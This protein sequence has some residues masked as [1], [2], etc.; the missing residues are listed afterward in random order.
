M[1]ILRTPQIFSTWEYRMKWWHIVK[2]YNT[3][4]ETHRP[5]PAMQR[6]TMREKLL[7]LLPCGT[8]WLNTPTRADRASS[9]NWNT[10]VRVNYTEQ[11]PDF[12]QC[13]RLDWM[14]AVPNWSGAPNTD[15]KM[16]LMHPEKSDMRHTKLPASS[17]KEQRAGLW[18]SFPK[19]S[20]ASAGAGLVTK[21][22][23]AF[24]S[25]SSNAENQ[26]TLQEDISV[27]SPTVVPSAG[28]A[29]RAWE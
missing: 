4:A 13:A 5:I 19:Q 25:W 14:T 8:P 26:T 27:S 16:R 12:R 23:F 1:K 2:S 22:L 18:S 21:F 3:L 7:P 20:R 15:E 24:W 9:K 29:P 17:L 6:P 11:S 28:F 10:T